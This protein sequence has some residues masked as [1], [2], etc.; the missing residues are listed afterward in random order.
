MVQTHH[1]SKSILD[2]E[3]GQFLNIL[4]IRLPELVIK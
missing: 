2:A 1:L 3:W 4:K